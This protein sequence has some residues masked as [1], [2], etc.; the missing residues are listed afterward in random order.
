MRK[1]RLKE[2]KAMMEKG[3]NIAKNLDVKDKKRAHQI[4]RDHYPFVFCPYCGEKLEV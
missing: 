3:L 4:L 1:S 2:K